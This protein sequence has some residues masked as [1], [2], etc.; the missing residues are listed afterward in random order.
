MFTNIFLFSF[1][2][3]YLI[4]D[5]PQVGAR[6]AEDHITYTIRQS[7]RVIRPINTSLDF[8]FQTIS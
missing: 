3:E 6:F 7:S 8:I 5:T 2:T 4:K 1:K